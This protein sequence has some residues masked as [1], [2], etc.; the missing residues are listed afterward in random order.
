MAHF[1]IVSIISFFFFPL[2]LA[3]SLTSSFQICKWLSFVTWLL[4]R[5]LVVPNGLH[6]VNFQLFSFFFS[7][8]SQSDVFGIGWIRMFSFP[9]VIASAIFSMFFMWLF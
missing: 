6:N 8:T 2:F 4:T 1:F 5:Q 9:F 7:H 3:A